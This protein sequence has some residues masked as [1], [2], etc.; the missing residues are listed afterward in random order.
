MENGKSSRAQLCSIPINFISIFAMK[1]DFAPLHLERLVCL[2]L[3]NQHPFRLI[4]GLN[5]SDSQYF[6]H[7]SPTVF[8]SAFESSILL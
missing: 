7:V 1:S 8:L 3:F 5:L 6:I 4:L 2:R